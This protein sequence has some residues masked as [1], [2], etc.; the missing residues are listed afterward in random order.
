[1]AELIDAPLPGPLSTTF[2]DD[3]DVLAFLALA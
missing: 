3:L 1:L 2:P